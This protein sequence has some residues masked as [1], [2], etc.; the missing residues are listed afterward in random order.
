MIIRGKPNDVE[1]YILVDD[2]VSVELHK[3]GFI[4]KYI[5]EEGIYFSKSIE[6][7]EYMERSGL[8]WKN[9]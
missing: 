4:P 8:T 6:V 3:E 9:Q 5:N 2:N 1:N 7:L